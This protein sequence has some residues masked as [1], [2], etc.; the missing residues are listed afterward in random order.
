VHR[1]NKQS[2]TAWE[3]GEVLTSPYLKKSCYEILQKA[4]ESGGGLL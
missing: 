4:S 3:L 1:L 2:R